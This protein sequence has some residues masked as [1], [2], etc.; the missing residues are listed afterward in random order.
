MRPQSLTFFDRPALVL[1]DSEDAVRLA[2]PTDLNLPPPL[3]ALF[4]P[5]LL[6]RL[7]A[8][9]LPGM[10]NI[11]LLCFLLIFYWGCRHTLCIHVCRFRTVVFSHFC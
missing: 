9:A 11:D 10:V 7:V 1:C 5:H 8:Y 2:C 3:L 6:H 4:A